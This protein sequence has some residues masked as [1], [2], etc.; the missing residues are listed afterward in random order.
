[1][2]K[3][4]KLFFPL[5]ILPFFIFGQRENNSL[6]EKQF[7][8]QRT[9]Y[10]NI[11]TGLNYINFR[12]FATSPLFY[13]GVGTTLNLSFFNTDEKRE[14]DYSFRGMGGVYT[15]S[16]GSEYSA[17]TAVASI[18]SYTQL[19]QIRKLSSEK[20]NLKI[21]ASANMAFNVR[22]NNAFMNNGVGFELIP[23][24]FGSVKSSFDISR[25]NVKY[26]DLWLVQFRF[27]ERKMKL[28][29]LINVG[30]INSSYRN[31]FIYNNQS[32]L[33]N[34]VRPFDGYVFSA[35]SGFGMNTSIDF[36]YFLKNQNTLIIYYLWDAYK[37]G[38]EFDKF[39]FAGHS[40]VF[41][42]LFNTK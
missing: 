5:M 4:A 39:E 21:G 32:F 28:S 24:L 7:Q 38:G 1:M 11:G 35:F 13:S 26:I 3:K 10:I 8:K 30:V 25:K 19:Y 14:T 12:D 29:Y 2:N 22:F 37:T 33:V 6:S 40:L 18:F 42:L 15:N 41:S 36:T 31:G 27:D 20:F 17:S 23:T 16:I 9:S 34:D